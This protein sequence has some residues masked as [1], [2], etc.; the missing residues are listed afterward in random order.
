MI[1]IIET[2][3]YE[4]DRLAIITMNDAVW[5]T[6]ERPWWDI[7]SWIWWWLSPGKKAWLLLQPPCGRRFRIRA[8]K[9]AKSY[10]RVGTLPD[11]H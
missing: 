10:V 5:L 11:K 8:M 7:A 4:A 6:F 1:E 2:R 3:V 9:V